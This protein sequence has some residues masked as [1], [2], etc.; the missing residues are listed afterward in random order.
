MRNNDSLP[1][2]YR[3][4][5]HLPHYHWQRSG[6]C[7]LDSSSARISST[8]YFLLSHYC[9]SAGQKHTHTHTH[10]KVISSGDV[11]LHNESVLQ[12]TKKSLKVPLRWKC[13]WLTHKWCEEWQ[14]VRWTRPHEV[15]LFEELS[16]Y[17]TQKH[18]DIQLVFNTFTFRT[19]NFHDDGRFYLYSDDVTFSQ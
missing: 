11:I 2:T 8:V 18:T 9:G 19:F 15:E 16:T 14:G 4:I 17:P 1:V 10:T 13:L 6:H 12:G 5:K 7:P 3:V